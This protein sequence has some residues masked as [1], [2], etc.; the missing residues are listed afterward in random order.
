MLGI[1]PQFF[2]TRGFILWATKQTTNGREA[3]YKQA[4]E[5]EEQKRIHRDRIRAGRKKI[6]T[7]LNKIVI[8]LNQK[9]LQEEATLLQEIVKILTYEYNN[10]R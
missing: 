10:N 2:N 3:L 7:N 5:E 8:N 1:T 6:L 9:G 4:G